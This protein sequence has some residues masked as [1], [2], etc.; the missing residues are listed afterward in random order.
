[1]RSVGVC[2]E[3][4]LGHPGRDARGSERVPRP[5]VGSAASVGAS[6]PG[7]RFAKSGVSARQNLVGFLIALLFA[8]CVLLSAGAIAL[9]IAATFYGYG[10]LG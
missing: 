6:N 10:G 2:F 9:L 4:A 7:R 3:N 5:T 8:A 1:M